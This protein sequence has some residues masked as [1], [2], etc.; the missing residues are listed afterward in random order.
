M[1]VLLSLL[2]ALSVASAWAQGPEAFPSGR[3]IDCRMDLGLFGLLGGGPEYSIQ[4]RPIRR[5]EDFKSVIYPL[6]DREASDL[7]RESGSAH[8]TASIFYMTGA[9]VAV[10]VA[11]NF[12]PAPLL[13][14]DWIDRT[15]TGLAI[16]QLFWGVGVLFDSNA[17]ARRFNA[18]QRYNHLLKDR[19]ET[20][21]V[22]WAA[23][24]VAWSGDGARCL[25][26]ARF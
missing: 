15:A 10:D 19:D 18:V 12:R 8:L 25:L 2:F 5:D 20:R 7:L 11:L 3:P 26:G 1:R 14:V 22:E 17:G 9:A 13:G 6:G 24:Q 21:S 4:G 23:P 16:G